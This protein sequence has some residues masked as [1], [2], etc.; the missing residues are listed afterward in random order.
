MKP[1]EMNHIIQV[2]KAV[3]RSQNSGQSYSGFT[4]LQDVYISMKFI[5]NG[6]KPGRHAN[7]TTKNIC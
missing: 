7:K 3:L 6:Y 2:I 5:T 4:F 1:R